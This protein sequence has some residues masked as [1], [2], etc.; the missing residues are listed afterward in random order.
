M[1]TSYSVIFIQF[2]LFLIHNSH[3]YTPICIRILNICVYAH[4]YAL[5][6]YMMQYVMYRGFL[7]S[8]PLIADIVPVTKALK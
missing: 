3:I 1:D 2:V 8:Q 5:N 4:S 6:V 7:I